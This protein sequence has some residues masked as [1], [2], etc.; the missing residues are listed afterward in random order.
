VRVSERMKKWISMARCLSMLVQN[1]PMVAFAVETDNLCEH[2][3]VYTAD[4]GYVAAVEDSPC[5]HA[6]EE[7]CGYA[8]AVEVNPITRIIVCA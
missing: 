4:C 7:A 6:H 5:T 2:H 8:Q 1:C 3:A